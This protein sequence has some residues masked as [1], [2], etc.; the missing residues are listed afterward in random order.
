MKQTF[1]VVLTLLGCHKTTDSILKSF[2]KTVAALEAH[3]VQQDKKAQVLESQIKA[4]DMERMLLHSD[5]LK[6]S[7]P[8]SA[9]SP[10]LTKKKPKKEK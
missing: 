6:A 1:N 7:V 4:L 2:H 10:C 5:S 9:S 8:L 3:S